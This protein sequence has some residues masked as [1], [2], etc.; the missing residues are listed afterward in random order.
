[1][2]STSIETADKNFML[3]LGEG[4]AKIAKLYK[5]IGE[6]FGKDKKPTISIKD[7]RNAEILYYMRLML[8]HPSSISI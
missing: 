1:M 8:F 6:H 2:E 7:E 3:V 4:Y 5:A